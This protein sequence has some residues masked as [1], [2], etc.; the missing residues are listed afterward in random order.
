MVRQ[1]VVGYRTETT[2]VIEEG[3]TCVGQKVTGSNLGGDQEFFRP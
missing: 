1:K 3:C 2:E